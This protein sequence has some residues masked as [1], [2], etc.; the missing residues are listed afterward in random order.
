M[1]QSALQG[2]LRTTGEIGLITAVMVLGGDGNQ[3]VVGLLC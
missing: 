2:V 3:T 1:G